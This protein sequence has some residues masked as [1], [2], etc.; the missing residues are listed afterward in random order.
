MLRMYRA[1][2]TAAGGRRPPHLAG[3]G[4]ALPPLVGQS[5]ADRSL[6]RWTVDR[7]TIADEQ[8]Q[9]LGIQPVTSEESSYLSLL[10][11]LSLSIVGFSTVVVAIRGALGGEL[12][13][14]HLRLVRLYIEGGLL[15]TALAVLPALLSLLHISAA[16]TWSLSSAT[17][18][19]VYSFVLVVQFR[20]R[21]AVEPG[22]FPLWVIVVDGLSL[23]AIAGLC[24]NVRGVPNPPNIGPYAV[25]LT[26]SLCMFGFIFVRTIE[27]FLHRAPGS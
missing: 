7:I 13:D 9:T 15:V 26:W 6:R 18:A 12:S 23:L 27:L 20:R 5:H 1:K 10:A 21:R 22:P 2:Y 24:M 16:A 8:S 4:G 25:V 14:R 17:A 3:E 11:T 19:L